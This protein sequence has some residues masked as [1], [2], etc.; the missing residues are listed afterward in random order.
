V[1]RDDPLADEFVKGREYG[2][3]TA[4][5]YCDQATAKLV[6]QCGLTTDEHYELLLFS[7]HFRY[8]FSLCWRGE[9]LV[10]IP[11]PE[12]DVAYAGK[13]CLNIGRL[14]LGLVPVRTRALI[15]PRN[16]PEQLNIKKS[17]RLPDHCCDFQAEVNLPV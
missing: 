13:W 6:G 17:F 14:S 5:S 7:R 10:K 9:R 15:Y 8:L 1:A 2:Q 11:R 3:N 16:M 12:Y 4:R